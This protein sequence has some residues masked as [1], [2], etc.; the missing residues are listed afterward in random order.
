MIKFFRRIRRKLIETGNLKKYLTYAIGE[1]LLVMVG[2]LLALQ[3]SN[4]NENKKL[5]KLERSTLLEISDALDSDLSQLDNLLS[6]TH[7]SKSNLDTVLGY[8]NRELPYSPAIDGMWGSGYLR[9]IYT[10]N[11]SSFDLLKSRG[12]DIIKDSELRKQ[13]QIHYDISIPFFLKYVERNYEIN[14]NFRNKYLSQLKPYKS[15]RFVY[16]TA[17]ID[18]ESMRNDQEI[19]AGLERWRF[20]RGRSIEELLKLN[21][22]TNRLK[23]NINE[24]LSNER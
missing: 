15:K 16:G 19:L 13:I 14:E 17:P 4:W 7:Q 20:F 22:L 8:L 21:Q 23:D 18:L 9:P 12:F 11:L 5:R 24:S 10:F 3:V 1:V 6:I 2:I